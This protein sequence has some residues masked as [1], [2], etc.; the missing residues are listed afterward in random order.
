METRA[1]SHPGN[2]GQSVARSLLQNPGYEVLC[3]TRNPASAKA[4]ALQDLG[5]NVTKADGFDTEQMTE[6][7]SGCWGL[8]LNTN[9]DD[10]VSI[11]CNYSV[12]HWELTWT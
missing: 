9:S 3:L 5:A 12:R 7:L 4:N 1:D 2:Q 11:P 10:P 6:I 8:F